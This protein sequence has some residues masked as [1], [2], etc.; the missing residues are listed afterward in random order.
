MVRHRVPHRKDRTS[1]CPKY[2]RSRRKTGRDLAFV[3]IDGRRLYLGAYGTAD[4]RERYHR[5][6]AEW[7]ANGRHLPVAADDITVT[8]VAALFLR[9]AR[10]YY[11]KHGKRTAE[12][13]NIA[14]AVRP[15]KKLYGRTPAAEFGPRAL[16]AVRQK[17]IDRG[18]TRK[19]INRH[20]DR[21]KRMFKW[22][23]AEELVPPGLYEGLRA[24]VGLRYGRCKAPDNPPVLPVPEEVVE[25]VK[26]HVSRQVAAM[27]DL[28]LLTGARPGEIVQMR[29]CDI[30]M[31][32]R[33]WT[34][35]PAEHKTEHHGHERVIYLGPKARQVVGPFLL[36]PADAHC[37][38][39]AEAEHERRRLLHAARTAPIGSGNV[40]GTNRKAAPRR[41]PGTRYTT[42]SCRRAIDRGIAAA[43]PPPEELA[44]RPD[45]T[46]AQYEARLTAKDKAAVKAWRRK[47]HWHPHQLRHNY[48]TY[49]R[50][51]FGLEA[52]QILL[53]HSKADVTQVYAERDMGRAAEVA[54]KIG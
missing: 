23:V 19:Y 31:S 44:Q 5:L 9:W 15:A 33:V 47:H 7:V 41:K 14:L 39:P 6:L 52:A 36:R 40:P 17:M 49:V 3:E 24:V 1:F 53:G 26:R 4:S 22:A 34:Y 11:V 38:S 21:I 45:E 43:F 54:A 28:Q 42:G 51:E 16:K 35:R 29:P 2:R 50:R 27:I 12:P 48:A 13:E 32:G 18:W 37:F 30:D 46:R 8:G 25:P 20:V 10:G